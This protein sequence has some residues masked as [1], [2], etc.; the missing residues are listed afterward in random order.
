MAQ[1]GAVTHVTLFLVLYEASN[2]LCTGKSV[3]YLKS[4][5]I[6][7]IYA[8]ILYI[9]FIIMQINCEV[10]EAGKGKPMHCLELSVISL[11]V[12]EPLI[13]TYSKVL[14]GHRRLGIN[15]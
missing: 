9:C 10:Y 6:I 8:F 1:D 2:L 11:Y 5:C 3:S 14:D 12:Y 7:H 13:P 4:A 15:S